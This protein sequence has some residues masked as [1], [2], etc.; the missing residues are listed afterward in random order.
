LCANRTPYHVFQYPPPPPGGVFLLRQYFSL[1]SPPCSSDFPRQNGDEPSPSVWRRNIADASSP[2]DKELALLK[3]TLASQHAFGPD[4]AGK[5]L[6]MNLL[7]PLIAFPIWR[8]L[9]LRS[10]GVYLIFLRPCSSMRQQDALFR[11][12]FLSAASQAFVLA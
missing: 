5:I 6:T 8:C 4:S 3:Q 9:F 10:T 2:Q 12:V 1:Y 11:R 7:V